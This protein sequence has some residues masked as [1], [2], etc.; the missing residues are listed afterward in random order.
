M[1][2][3]QGKIALITGGTSGIGLA[4][5]RLFCKEGAK[6]AIVGR[7]VLK[8]E[9]SVELIKRE[10]GEAIYIQADVSVSADVKNMVKR[11]LENYGRIDILFNN[12]GT[13]QWKEA[14]LKSQQLSNSLKTLEE[15]TE[16][17]WD[18]IINTNLKSVFLCCKYVVPHM[19]KQ[20]GGVIINTASTL[21]FVGMAGCAAYCA[22]KGG[23][24]Q[25]TRALA[26]ELAPYNIRVN[27]VC[28]G[29]TVAETSEGFV[30]YGRKISDEA[31]RARAKSHPLGRLARPEDIAHAVL[32]LASEES[33]FVTG[34]ALFV[35]G[36]YTAQ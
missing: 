22:S 33:S 36:G 15:L 27:C 9:K 11:T 12:A 17:D 24:V 26:I 28:P 29:T 19:K 20:G 16:E 25:L 7:N 14:E 31:I 6:V 35:D 8:G 32:Y 3:L 5:A 13:Q 23:V 2:R 30:L 21:G 4:T 18:T 10:G 1:S 34:T